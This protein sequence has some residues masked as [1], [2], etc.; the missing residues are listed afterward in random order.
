MPLRPLKPPYR[1]VIV[2]DHKFV[3]ETLA[4]RLAQDGSI[5]VVGL[6]NHGSSA[7]HLVTTEQV[8][9]VLLDMELEQENGL[10]VAKQLLAARPALRIMG[11]SMHDA[12]HYP[13]ALLE[14]GALGFISKRATAR[15]IGDAVRRIAHG[16]MAISAAIAVRLVTHGPG[17]PLDAL[18]A[19]TVKETEILQE[20]ALG[21][22]VKS[23][24]RRLRLTEK[25][26]QSHRN[27]VRR[28]LGADTDVELCLTAIRAG[29]IDIHT[30]RDASGLK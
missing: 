11:L 29:L 28:K 12:D 26:I 18:K 23:I 16:E 4:Q 13:V 25:T 2:D 22:S 27:H 8:D 24:A 3:C 1:L 21:Y 5:H 9:I 10:N 20:I 14:A 17:G 30:P 15:E 6:A 19:L 7:L